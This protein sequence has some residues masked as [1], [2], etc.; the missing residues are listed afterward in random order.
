MNAFHVIV[1]DVWRFL[2]PCACAST[3][4]LVDTVIEGK[5]GFHMGRLSVDVRLASSYIPCPA[6][7]VFST[8]MYESESAKRFLFR[9]FFLPSA[10]SW[11]RLT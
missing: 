6:M 11:S 1:I 8:Y 10:T 9:P 3:G 5:T 2:Q 7:D 4:G